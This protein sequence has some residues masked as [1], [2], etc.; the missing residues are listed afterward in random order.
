MLSQLSARKI[1]RQAA[2]RRRTVPALLESGTDSFLLTTLARYRDSDMLTTAWLRLLCLMTAATL[3]AFA[4]QQTSAAASPAVADFDTVCSFLFR[5][6]P[7]QSSGTTEVTVQQAVIACSGSSLVP[8]RIAPVLS[9]FQSS[10]TGKDVLK[11]FC[12][13]V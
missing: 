12:L 13:S 3:V 4:Q 10:F 2:T 11:H 9:P 8:L 1:P 7:D 6:Q 5:G